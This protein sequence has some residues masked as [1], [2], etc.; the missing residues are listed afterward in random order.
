MFHM[1]F[2]CPLSNFS[3]LWSVKISKS[4]RFAIVYILS[5]TSY[6]HHIALVS[7]AILTM[8]SLC[9]LSSILNPIDNGQ[10]LC[11][12]RLLSQWNNLGWGVWAPLIQCS[13]LA[14]IAAIA[15]LCFYHQ[16][17][18]TPVNFLSWH[19]T[20]SCLYYISTTPHNNQ[21]QLITPA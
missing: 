11:S 15:H 12:F 8:Y 19:H 9:P 7:E 5:G 10:H 2:F 16:V 13:S 21:G 6:T 1:K 18:R 20:F 3:W 17:G 4:K 14:R